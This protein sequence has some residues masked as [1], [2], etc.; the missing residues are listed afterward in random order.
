MTVPTPGNREKPATSNH[1][2]VR[3]RAFMSICAHGV[4][5]GT[6]RGRVSCGFQRCLRPGPPACGSIIRPA[7]LCRADCMFGRAAVCACLVQVSW[8]TRLTR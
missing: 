3:R 2:K 1:H 5:A 7:P 6:P 4:A 8:L